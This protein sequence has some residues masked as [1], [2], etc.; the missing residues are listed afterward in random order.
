MMKKIVNKKT[1]KTST[2][3]KK[4]EYDLTVSFNDQIFNIQ[5]DNLAEAITEIIP[6]QLKTRVLF[7]IKKGDL[8]CE[9]M[10]L[11]MEGRR[12]FRNKIALEV[13]INRLI[14]K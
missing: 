2:A 3:P 5:T 6:F 10:L 1:K 7:L 13:F 4:K 14:F 11:L 12:V 9:K 8:T